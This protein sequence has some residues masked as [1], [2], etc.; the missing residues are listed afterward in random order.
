[1]Q[2]L[3]NKLASRTAYSHSK[4]HNIFQHALLR[5][6]QA[7]NCNTQQEHAQ[8]SSILLLS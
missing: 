6:W 7:T 2:H 8:R 5:L 3:N 4:P 1:M